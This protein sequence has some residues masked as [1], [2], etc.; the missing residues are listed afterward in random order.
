[1][2]P[3]LGLKGAGVWQIMKFFPGLWLVVDSLFI[4]EKDEA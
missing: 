3:E 1:L 4:V 2:I